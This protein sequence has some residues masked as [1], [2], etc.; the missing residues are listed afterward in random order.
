M[1]FG[2]I[3]GFN[4]FNPDGFQKNSTL[5]VEIVGFKVFNKD[6]EVNEEILE[7]NFRNL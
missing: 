1:Y 7:G 6:V 5:K 2:G 3:N 4:K